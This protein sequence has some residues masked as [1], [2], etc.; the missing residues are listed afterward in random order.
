MSDREA[1][2]N[3]SFRWR[4]TYDGAAV[5]EYT[6][7]GREA[8]I[9][10]EADGLPVTEIASHAFAA[11]GSSLEV[12][13]V[14]GSVRRILPHAFE[15]C[16]ELKTLI[17]EEGVEE[18]GEDFAA[19]TSL[20]ELVIPASVK[21]IRG[22]E[23]LPCRVTFAPGS[24]YYETDGFGIYRKQVL[25]GL[26]RG[27]ETGEF[28][29]R[30]GTEEIA[31]GVFNG[32]ERL[33]SV[34]LPSSVRVIPEGLFSNVR[35]MYSASPGITEIR[36]GPD[37]PVF[38]TDRTGLYERLGDDGRLRL[39]RWL[40]G[41]REAVLPDE[42]AEIG[43]MAF[44][45][46]G[47]HSLRT[48]SGLERIGTDA[49]A[50][51]A[52]RDVMFSDGNR[53]HIPSGNPYLTKDLLRGFGR[54]GQL[55][56]YREYDRKISRWYPDICRA[57]MLIS[58]L[59]LPPEADEEA[60]GNYLGMIRGHYSEIVKI[61][62]EAARPDLL[63]QLCGLGFPESDGDAAM[64][65]ACLGQLNRPEMAAIIMA[66]RKEHFGNKIFDFSL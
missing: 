38:F 59:A 37:N 28:L 55:Y 26:Q 14:P 15:L 54:G 57:E 65:V 35:N 48:G 12:I 42:V 24:R 62:G 66:Y 1:A 11:H 58:R 7:D 23:S 9:P 56:D 29:V 47:I 53:V 10:R 21:R 19:A 13:R 46:C 27:N 4:E 22:A 30:E 51:C 6:G 20:E 34:F 41:G 39:H 25:S 16:V 60:R 2:E 36:V 45:R 43:S 49:F 3:C 8:D 18:L 64:A 40:G 63:K 5:T 33:R 52:L 31:Q 50:G 61:L 32:R 17:L 44:L